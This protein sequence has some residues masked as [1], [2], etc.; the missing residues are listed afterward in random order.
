[1]LPCR[2]IPAFDKPG[3]NRLP[4]DAE[5]K[6][7]NSE[8]PLTMASSPTTVTNDPIRSEF[9]N[10]PDMAEIVSMFVSEM[11]EKIANLNKT[12]QAMQF[13]ELRRLAHQIKGSSGGYGFS[14]LG[15]AAGRLE[16][17][18][19]T[20]GEGGGDGDPVANIRREFE[21]LINLCKRVT[22]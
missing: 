22:A 9:A 4:R 18:L 10:D 6:G 11:P 5:K 12:F 14:E 19:V 21:Q 16:H 20:H 3:V 17:L 15:K 13:D 1:M 8:V 7:V 2:E